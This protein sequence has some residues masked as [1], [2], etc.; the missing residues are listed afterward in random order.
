MTEFPDRGVRFNNSGPVGGPV[1]Q[2]G[3]ASAVNVHLPGRSELEPPR[4]VPLAVPFFTDRVDVMASLDRL[5]DEADRP[6]PRAVVLTGPRGVGKSAVVRRW[7]HMRADQYPD[8]QIY[9]NLGGTPSD[10]VTAADV[11]ASVLTRLG[12]PREE[13][14][15]LLDG[16]VERFR[17]AVAGKRVLLVLDHAMTASQVSPFMTSSADVVVTASAALGALRLHGARFRYV[18]CLDEPFAIRPATPEFAVR[19][20]R[21][22]IHAVAAHIWVADPTLTPPAPYSVPHPF[23]ARSL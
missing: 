10:A 4:E 13:L 16:R 20:R 23:A 6:A 12:V 22:Q 9:V 7:A 14:G 19:K 3:A 17:S 15:G 2:V 11:A 8:G 21:P 18:D 1:F 5:C